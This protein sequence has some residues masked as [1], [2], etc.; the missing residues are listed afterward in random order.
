MPL[1]K[2]PKSSPSNPSADTPMPGL[3]PK[4]YQALTE[5]APIMIWRAAADG[6]CD[7]VNAAW[8]AF[9][10]QSQEQARGEGW[11]QALHPDDAGSWHEALRR[12][13]ARGKSFELECRLRRADGAWRDMLVR[14]SPHHDEH[15]TLAGAIAAW[16]D[17]SERRAM[18]RASADDFF[19]MS[20]DNVCVAGFDGYFKR[21][22]AS[23]TRT[24]GWTAEELM[25]R[26]ILDFAH[27]DD[28]AGI[29]AARARLHHAED[30]GPL[31]NRY[32]CKDGSYR[33]F[34]WRSAADIERRLVY[35]VAR[36]I[37]EQKHADERLRESQAREESLRRQLLFADRMASMGTLAA[38]VAHEINNPLA[39]V[40]ANINTLLENIQG[41]GEMNAAELTTLREMALEACEGADRIHRIIDGLKSFSRPDE[42]QHE[43]VEIP[44]LLEKAIDMTF[45]EIRHRARLVRDIGATPPVKA[46][47]TRLGQVFVNLLVNAAQAIPDGDAG[48]A[49]IRVNTGTDPQG[50][51]VIE[52]S[53]T[54]AG[55]PADMIERV[56]DPFFTTK[57]VGIG[58]GL[59]LY[60]CHN[61]V[62]ALGG[63]IH[64]AASDGGRGTTFRVTLPAAAA[65]QTE[66]AAA[67]P[68]APS[69]GRAVVL[70]V[71]DEPFIGHALR[72]ILREHDVTAVTTALDA[73]A[74]LEQGRRFD[75]IFSDIMMPE[76]SGMAFH[77]ELTRRFPDAA[78][79]VVFISGGTFTAGANAFL[80]RVPNE[81]LAKPFTNQEVRE[82][83][84][85]YTARKE[86]G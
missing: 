71:D 14:V 74:L 66:P 78:A 54:G 23:W 2:L 26:P 82:I 52:I 50:G 28:R 10:G 61:I 57:P 29:L 41:C 85:R 25:A 59:G 12:H 68:P 77:E 72:R 36:D 83:V 79:K 27:P 7:Y 16:L 20:R 9:S 55:I 47:K 81:F 22:N 3:P 30:M 40:T 58:T 5:Q 76:M 84:Q 46:D 21:V 67:P 42:E 64:A 70:V 39:Y 24:L 48:R 15:G 69:A 38:G 51:A 56:F 13:L 60:I 17:I 65:I 75:L 43:I 33:W 86:S 19:E 18:A 31:I 1:S 44:P 34:E 80:A 6:R 11:A 8:R 35:A 62:T 45:N 53:D 63:R 73:L 37:T 4:Q 49:E 32:R